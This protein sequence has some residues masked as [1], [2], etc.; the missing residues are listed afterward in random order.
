MTNAEIQKLLDDATGLL[1]QTTVG[2]ANHSAGWQANTSTKWWQAL[3]K[4]AQARKAL[5]P[6]TTYTV[7]LV[8]TPKSGQTM[9]ATVT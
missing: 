1:K 2:Y 3:D 8:G 6:P 5:N 9:N 4:I 7:T